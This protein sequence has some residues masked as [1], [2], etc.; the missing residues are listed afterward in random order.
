MAV[1]IYYIL[2]TLTFKFCKKQ[3]DFVVVGLNSDKS[4]KEIKG[5]NRPINSFQIRKAFTELKG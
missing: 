2:A 3:G 4:V 1:L 5:Q